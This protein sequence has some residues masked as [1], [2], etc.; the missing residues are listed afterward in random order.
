MHQRTGESL[1]KVDSPVPLLHHNLSDL[2]SMVLFWLL[3]KKHT[4]HEHATT[5]LIACNTDDEDDNNDHD[6]A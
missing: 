4:K 1:V 6:D 5:I 2:R 3:L